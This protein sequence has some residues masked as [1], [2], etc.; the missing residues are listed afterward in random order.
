MNRTSLKILIVFALIFCFTILIDAQEKKQEQPQLTKLT[1]DELV[2]E[3]KNL[4]KQILDINTNLQNI[5]SKYKLL[6]S[7]NVKTVPY[8]VTYT[9]GENYI[10]IKKYELKR[11]ELLDNKVIGLK[12]RKIKVFVN[13]Q[14]ISKI[15]SEITEKNVGADE[16]TI[17]K[18]ID[19][20]PTA[21]GTDDIVF[22]HT[23]S[24][25]KLIE[26]KK[27]R[28]IKNNRAFPVRNTIKRE[29][30][31]PHITFLYNTVLKI[32]ELHYQSIKDTDNLM[33]DFLKKST[34][35]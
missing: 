34:K 26:N 32:C 29:F 2:E 30:L 24:G 10:E 33:A 14:N 18:I 25:R 35:Y 17:V 12:E 3:G 6:D 22:S 15:E 5:I 21:V 11:D 27:M 28:E 7:K 13:G 19:P 9:L 16:G 23:V 31:I 4:D 1:S 20:S 8:R